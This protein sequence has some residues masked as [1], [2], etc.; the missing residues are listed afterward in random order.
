VSRCMT[1][2]PAKDLGHQCK[3]GRRIVAYGCGLRF[4]LGLRGCMVAHRRVVMR[5]SDESKR[6]HGLE[7]FGYE[8]VQHPI[9]QN[10]GGL[11]RATQDL[12]KDWIAAAM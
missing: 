9:L 11:R 2:W 4:S 8:P 6:V 10:N 3:S 1:R 12:R 7:F 5:E